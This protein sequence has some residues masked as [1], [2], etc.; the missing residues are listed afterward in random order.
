LITMLFML[1]ILC[2]TV[3]YCNEMVLTQNIIYDKNKQIII[4]TKETLVDSQTTFEKL[5][6][7]CLWY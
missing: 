6:K 1:Y 7:M 2:C 4:L 3:Q 5:R